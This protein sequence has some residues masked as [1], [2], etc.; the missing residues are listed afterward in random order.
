M[1]LREFRMTE[2]DASRHDWAGRAGRLRECARCRALA[3]VSNGT[4]H[5]LN[6]PDPSLDCARLGAIELDSGIRH[7]GTS[8]N[9]HVESIEPVRERPSGH[10]HCRELEAEVG[11]VRIRF[12]EGNDPAYVA[13]VLRALGNAP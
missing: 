1:A 6:P 9:T 5:L 8:S 4:Y 11:A 12:G 13:A 10:L 3:E 2:H 7:E